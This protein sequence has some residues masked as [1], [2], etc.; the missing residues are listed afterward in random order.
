MNKKNNVI[1]LIGMLVF[2]STQAFAAT[3]GAPWD[4]PIDT[5][6]G[7]LT[8]KLALG[9]SVVALVV[10]GSKAL[11]SGGELSGFAK[12]LILVVIGASTI[13]GAVALFNLLFSGQGALV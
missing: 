10:A 1:I 13:V 5:L 9:L 12:T 3:S 11:F 6:V 4:G 8:G 7:W 2:V